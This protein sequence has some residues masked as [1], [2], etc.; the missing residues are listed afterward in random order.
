MKVKT[1]ADGAYYVD[2]AKDIGAKLDRLAKQ[3]PASIAAE[4][5]LDEALTIICEGDA[6]RGWATDLLRRAHEVEAKAA[7]NPVVLREHQADLAEL[8]TARHA[9]VVA[10]EGLA[11]F[12]KILARYEA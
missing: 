1:R 3:T 8:R 10:G 9:L 6:I 2:G 5:L 7:K 4:A 11:Y 12:E